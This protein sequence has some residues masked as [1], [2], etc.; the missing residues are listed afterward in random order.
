M[1]PDYESYSW[2]DHDEDCHG[3]IDTNEMREDFPDGFAWTCCDK[4]GSEP[5]CKRGRHQS[6]PEKSKK[7]MWESESENSEEED[8]ESS[9][10]DDSDL[11]DDLEDDL[12]GDY[13]GAD[14]SKEGEH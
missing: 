3:T 10:E 9:E 13:D 1:E 6:N 2:A 14:D 4:L 8:D 11:E 5:G 7:G 12:E